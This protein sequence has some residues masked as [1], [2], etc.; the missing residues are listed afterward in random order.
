MTDIDFDELDKAVS[1]V[2]SDKQDSPEQPSDPKAEA[3]PELS[4]SERPLPK[5]PS[6]TRPVG[7]ARPNTG[8]FMDV[9]PASPRPTVTS[10]VETETATKPTY[11]PAQMP[12]PIDLH[13]Q[14]IA[15]EPTGSLA[16]PETKPDAEDE[17]SQESGS[18]FLPDTKVEKRP[19]GAFSG[20][21][22]K[23]SASTPSMVD[24]VKESIEKSKEE[25]L[26]EELHRDL[27]KVEGDS[28]TKESEIVPAV[29]Q[30]NVPM[31]SG[32]GFINPTAPTPVFDTKDYHAPLKHIPKKKSGW[33][34]ILWVLAIIVIGGAV[35]A[36][37]YFIILS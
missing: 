14:K 13:E 8:R 26:P 35:G 9:M 11:N 30:V 4:R 37:V 28:T 20:S 31:Q 1:S 2:I 23:P 19:L 15:N 3:K 18:P 32:S 17:K 10:K 29:N 24:S 12:D 36:F 7:V 27:L 21:A 5:I 33:L 34:T 25:H 6:A 22:A 16:K